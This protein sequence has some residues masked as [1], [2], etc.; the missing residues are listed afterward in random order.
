MGCNGGIMDNAF[1]YI[2]DK[3]I[4]DEASYPYVGKD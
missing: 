2:V 4:T 1:E 3:G